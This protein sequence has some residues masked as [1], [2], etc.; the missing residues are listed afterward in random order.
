M[1]LHVV[2]KFVTWQEHNLPSVSAQ[3]SCL[4]S[5]FTEFWTFFWLAK[6]ASAS[7]ASCSS[8]ATPGYSTKQEISKAMDDLSP[9]I[10]HSVVFKLM[11][12][13]IRLD[14]WLR[15]YSS[16]KEVG[17]DL[18]CS[19]PAQPL[20]SCSELLH[21]WF[22]GAYFAHTAGNERVKLYPLTVA[23]LFTISFKLFIQLH[24]EC[25]LPIL[26]TERTKKKNRNGTRSED[27]RLPSPPLT[28]LLLSLPSPEQHTQTVQ[29]T[30]EQLLWWHQTLVS[31]VTSQSINQPTINL[32]QPACQHTGT[33]IFFFFFFFRLLLIE[34]RY[35]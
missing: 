31:Q 17:S 9:K 8:H 14:A 20:L 22:P 6:M 16:L 29:H 3:I 4:C 11:Y 18:Q 2:R 25:L 10:L 35:S 13:W 24:N 12:E 28:P 21:C 23:C 30:G 5:I 1:K 19:I 26:Q 33:G 7:S 27:P 15:R 32:T 34:E